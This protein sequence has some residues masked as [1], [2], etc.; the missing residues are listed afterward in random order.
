LSFV[1]SL[2]TLLSKEKEKKESRKKKEKEKG[3]GREISKR[4]KW[5]D[6]FISFLI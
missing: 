5:V 1:F 2:S 3:S 6:R 4:S